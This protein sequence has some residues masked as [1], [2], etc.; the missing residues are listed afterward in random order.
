MPKITVGPVI[1]KVTDTTARVLAEADDYAQVMCELMDSQG[2]SHQNTREMQRDRPTAFS[3]RNL[4]PETE[5]AITFLNADCDL[6]GRFRTFPK[7]PSAM[8]LLVVSC[9]RSI[10][11]GSTDLWADMS[12]KYVSAGECDMTLHIGDQVY[13]DAAFDT[14]L[15]KLR[16]GGIPRG[17]RVQ[18]EEILELYRARHRVAWNDPST[19]AVLASAPNL[20]ILDDHEIR[21]DW[22][23]GEF[24]K[25]KNSDEYYIGTLGRRAYREYQR[26]LWDDFDT[27]SDPQS[28]IEHHFH[29]WGQI[30]V[31]FL[32]QRGGRTFGYDSSKPYLSQ[33]QWNEVHAALGPGGTFD[34][35]S[36][37]L[38]VT[39]VPLV[40][41]TKRVG[42]I[43]QLALDDY[44]DHWSYGTHQPEQLE[45]IKALE[46][47][48]GRGAGLRELLV[49]GG[50]VHIGG[51]SRIKY[52]DRTIY[53]QIITSPI[54]NEPANWIEFHGTKVLLEIEDDLGGGYSFEH[55]DLTRQRNY[56]VV[57][58]NAPGNGPAQI[59]ATLIEADT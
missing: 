23:S 58:V 43:A 53:N 13:A 27:D 48:K 39:S 2:N 59:D 35:V 14:A 17:N 7:N 54:T 51:Y 5:Y 47:W 21:D 26:Q 25:D 31:M 15:H 29:S 20:M 1:G 12:R 9:N 4:R 40:Y 16:T 55:H 52:H 19:R 50:D 42:E 22:G 41:L 57:R 8:N 49:L 6:T 36:A 46:D 18:E 37:L 56:A 44:K 38:V 32:D 24:D 3:F 34:H 45:F 10:K 28:G 30:G 11:R 33:A